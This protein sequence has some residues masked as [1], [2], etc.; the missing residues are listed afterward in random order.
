MNLSVIRLDQ[1]N[2]DTNL[3]RV[4]PYIDDLRKKRKV[5]EKNYPLEKSKLS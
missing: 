1:M 5:I 3:D 4:P 2:H